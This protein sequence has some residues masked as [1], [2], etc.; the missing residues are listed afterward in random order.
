MNYICDK[1]SPSSQINQDILFVN[2]GPT[3]HKHNPMWEKYEIRHGTH[4]K[5]TKVRESKD[6][7]GLRERAESS[8]WE[9][10]GK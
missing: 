10:V 1:R 6:Y 3:Q 8:S 2:F 5:I 4:D 7:I 9:F